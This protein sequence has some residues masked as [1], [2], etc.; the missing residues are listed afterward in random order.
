MLLLAALVVAV[1]GASGCRSGRTARMNTGKYE[2]TKLLMGTTVTVT[3]YGEPDRDLKRA[4]DA[5]F[6]EIEK[7]SSIFSR[8]DPDSELSHLNAKGAG[9]LPVSRE[10]ADMLARCLE[11][12]HATDGAFDMTVGPLSAV[13]RKARETSN[14]PTEPDIREAMERTGCDKLT[15]DVKNRTVTFAT[16]GMSLDLGGIAKG[17]ITERA[18]DAIKNQ[19]VTRA[20]INAGGDITAVGVKPGGEM[21][22]LGIQ[23]PRVRGDYLAKVFIKDAAVVTSGDY[24]Q[25]FEKNGKRESHIIDPRTGHGAAE[26]ISVTVIAPEAELADALATGLSVLGPDKGLALLERR[27]P[28]AQA[29]I[30]TPDKKLHYSPGFKKFMNPQYH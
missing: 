22:T 21:W 8:Y 7:Q 28:Q 23:N 17:Y 29:L 11:I 4:A 19:G 16:P 3:L 18:A 14:A 9:T 12:C 30:I 27:F 10:M 1:L 6:T 26:T 20:L 15:V 25:Y 13:W 5:G 2:E 24:E